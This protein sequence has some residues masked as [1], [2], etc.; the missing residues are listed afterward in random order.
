MAVSAEYRDYL[1]DLFQPFP[2]V[3]FRPMFG[4]LGIFRDGA[5]FALV[6]REQLYFKVDAE[7]ESAFANAGAEPFEYDGKAKTV[8]L[9]YWT[10]PDDAMDDPDAF[11][12]WTELGL[13]AARR[14]QTKKQ[15]KKQKK[16]APRKPRKPKA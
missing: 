14:A 2:G 10:A 13:A 9:G 15:A 5:R 3:R 7:T 8:R 11:R 1:A 16:P 4:R 12:E 6:A